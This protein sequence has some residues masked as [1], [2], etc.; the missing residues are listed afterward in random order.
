MLSPLPGKAA[1]RLPPKSKRIDMRT[2]RTRPK[3]VRDELNG[4]RIYLRSASDSDA[5]PQDQRLAF[6]ASW[7][8]ST[9]IEDLRSRFASLEE[10]RE[11]D[12]GDDDLDRTRQPQREDA[13]VTEIWTAHAATLIRDHF[14]DELQRAFNEIVVR[15]QLRT[16]QDLRPRGLKREDRAG[17]IGFYEREAR[18]HVRSFVGVSGRGNESKRAPTAIALVEFSQCVDALRPVVAL[19]LQQL[20][21]GA[22]AWRSIVTESEGF[23]ALPRSDQRHVIAFL[24]RLTPRWPRGAA[25]EPAR[26]TRALA[27]DITGIDARA[28]GRLAAYYREGRRLAKM[29]K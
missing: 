24:Q 22:D 17:Y 4:V 3:R 15:I 18:R 16:Y 9:L 2:N 11:E 29:P 19:A 6:E 13:D 20:R 10:K 7:N 21:V 5:L 26:L 28:D 25:R 27:R 1:F 8:V 23:R 14:A 12:E